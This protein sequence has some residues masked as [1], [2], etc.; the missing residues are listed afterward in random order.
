MENKIGSDTVVGRSNLD[1]IFR[2]FKLPESMSI[3]NRIA[4]V[5]DWAA[6]KGPGTVIPYNIIYKHVYGVPNTPS[7]SNKD[8]VMLRKKLASARPI[9]QKKYNRQ[10]KSVAPL[11][12]RATTDSLDVVRSNIPSDVRRV[13][14]AHAAL[15]R[16]AKLVD[17]AKLPEGADKSYYVRTISPALKAL[18]SDERLAK[19]LPPKSPVDGGPQGK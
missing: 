11:G 10:L 15:Q 14:S 8:V 17:V 4:F 12:A 19:L 5:L 13:N 9:L 7:T 1:A 6:K 18:A 3:S 16:T 2:S